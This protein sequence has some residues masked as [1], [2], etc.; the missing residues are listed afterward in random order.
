MLRT[1][2]WNLLHL[3]CYQRKNYQGLHVIEFLPLILLS[4]TV[5]YTSPGYVP[6]L[7]ISQ[8][9]HLRECVSFVPIKTAKNRE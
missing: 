6:I 8:L 5:D 4:I 9:Q 2:I 1:L 7:Q 3:E